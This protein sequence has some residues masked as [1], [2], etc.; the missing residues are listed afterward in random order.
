MPRALPLTRPTQSMK[1]ISYVIYVSVL[2]S[3]LPTPLVHTIL[4]NETSAL[5]WA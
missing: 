1:I 5:S 4:N 3:T 2:D